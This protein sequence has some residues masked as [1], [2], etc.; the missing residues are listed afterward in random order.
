ME[1]TPEGAR[2]RADPGCDEQSSWGVVGRRPAGTLAQ[3]SRAWSGGA[4]SR[5][6]QRRPGAEWR[7]ETKPPAIER[8]LIYT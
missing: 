7:A 6:V 5:F 1:A 4:R 3:L 8:I 2:L